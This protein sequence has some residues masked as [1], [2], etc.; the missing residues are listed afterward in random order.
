MIAMYMLTAFALLLLGAAG[1]FIA[2]IAVASR[3]DKDITTPASS[4]LVRG[5]RT[6]NRLHT[7]GRGV[8]HEA[9]YR[10]DQPRLTDREW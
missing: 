2:V 7:R 8:L 10:H 6:A 9:A 1:G 4:R 3:R 5:A